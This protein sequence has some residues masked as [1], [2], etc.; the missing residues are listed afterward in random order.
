MMS[1]ADTRNTRR[2]PVEA[3]CRLHDAAVEHREAGRLAQ[4]QAAC[5]RSLRLLEQAVGPGH[6]DVANVLNTLALILRDRD[7]YAKAE[8]LA[9]RSVGIMEEISSDDEPVARIRVQSLRT[10]A[11][12]HRVRASVKGPAT[13][14]LFASSPSAPGR[15]K[16]SPVGNCQSA[17]TAARRDGLTAIS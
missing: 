10:L 7:R 15:T 4:A 1:A 12:I 3:A 14:S 5:R 11:G 17:E 9:Q 16:R 6:P 2:D 13:S 8:P